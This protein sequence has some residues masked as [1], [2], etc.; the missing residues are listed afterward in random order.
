MVTRVNRSL[1]QKWQKHRVVVGHYKQ[2]DAAKSCASL[3][4]TK[5]LTQV[6]VLGTVTYK[7][8]QKNNKNKQNP[9]NRSAVTFELSSANKSLKYKTETAI[10]MP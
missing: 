8:L 10:K 9:I 2:V 1:T 4:V 5:R 3:Q 7:H 6:A